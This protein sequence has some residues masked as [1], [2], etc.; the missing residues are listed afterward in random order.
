MRIVKSHLFFVICFSFFLILLAKNPFSTRTLIPN[1]DP[2][3][4]TLHYL[5][6]ID[7]LLRGQGFRFSRDEII[8][9]LA[10]VPPLYSFVLTPFV[11]IGADVRMFYF[12]NVLISLLSFWIFYLVVRIIAENKYVIGASLFLY[13]TNYYLYWYPQWAMAENLINLLYIFSCYL[14]LTNVNKKKTLAA[15]ANTIAIVA[16][17]YAYF[18]VSLAFAALY[19]LRIRKNAALILPY[20]VSGF[21]FFGL[22]LIYARHSIGLG[23]GTVRYAEMANLGA[24]WFS[25]RNLVE[26]ASRYLGSFVGG[27]STVLWENYPLWPIPISISGLIGIMFGFTKKKYRSISAFLFF[28]LAA[29]IGFMSSFHA[30]DARY[31]FHAI[32]AILLG[33][34]ILLTRLNLLLHSKARIYMGFTVLV[35]IVLMIH[36][37]NMFPRIKNQIALNIKRSEVPWSYVSVTKL[38]EYFNAKSEKSPIVVTPLPPYYVDFFSNGNYRLLPLSAHQEFRQNRHL[39]WGP[40]DYSDLISLYKGLLANGERVYVSTYGMGNQDLLHKDLYLLFDEFE[41]TEVLSECHDLCKLYS[42]TPKGL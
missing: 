8:G 35:G 15:A 32:P 1:L 4:D 23:T 29:Q 7:S 38:N 22:L 9:E 34:A 41:M 13:S 33:F 26:N 25:L 28:S 39:V 11:A 14:I 12:G 31:I 18:P 10:S 2:F 3:P 40:G 5:A 42:M 16:T 30:S 19:F 21:I 24:G 36:S 20:V 27:D 37:I 17:K 6:P